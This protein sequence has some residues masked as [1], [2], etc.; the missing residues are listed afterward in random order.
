MVCK[1]V[2]GSDRT[3]LANISL[4]RGLADARTTRRLASFLNMGRERA[5]G[6]TGLKVVMVYTIALC[7]C[8]LGYWNEWYV[9]DVISLIQVCLIECFFI[10]WFLF[11]SLLGDFL[12]TEE[13]GQLMTHTF[14]SQFRRMYWF[15]S[16]LPLNSSPLRTIISSL[17]PAAT[18]ARV[19]ASYNGRSIIQKHPQTPKIVSS[20]EITWDS[21]SSPLT[22]S[23]SPSGR[24][25]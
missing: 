23:P 7:S 3:A 13:K 1:L 20:Q 9:I 21:H 12:W 6:P 10:Q 11:V 16:L 19:T 5:A 24:R 25:N 22:S 2:M 17:P 4:R 8:D 18:S 15:Y 14:C